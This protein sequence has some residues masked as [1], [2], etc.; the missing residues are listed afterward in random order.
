[1]STTVIFG[2]GSEKG[3]LL[4]GGIWAL[5]NDLKNVNHFIGVSVGSILATFLAMQM[6]FPEIILESLSFNLFDNWLDLLKDFDISSWWLKS[7]K[8]KVFG[9]IDPSKIKERI[10]IWMNKKFSRSLSF[11]DLFLMTGKKLTITVTDRSDP[12]RPKAVYCNYINTPHISVS[13]TV[14]ESCLLPGI[15]ESNTPHRLDGAFSDPLPIEQVDS[16]SEKTII[17]LMEDVISESNNSLVKNISIIY[18]SLLIPSQI[19]LN[20]KLENCKNAKIINLTRNSESL[21]IPIVIP[22][23]REEKIALIA[24]GFHQTREQL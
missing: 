22:V 6:T 16:N 9:L 21:G 1:M 3:F 5:G 19:L 13:Q 17:F 20:N 23:K 12:K 14:L 18:H 7:N 15:F 24:Q 11:L 4:I 10:E 8:S 2:P